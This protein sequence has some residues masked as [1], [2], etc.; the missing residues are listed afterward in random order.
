MKKYEVEECIVKKEVLKQIICNTCGGIIGLKTPYYHIT[1][2]HND[3]LNSEDSIEYKDV[4]SD[5]CLIREILDYQAMDSNTKYIR[6][7]K[8]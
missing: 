5:S 8:G 7:E 3:W 2:G 1:T 4:C 6:I